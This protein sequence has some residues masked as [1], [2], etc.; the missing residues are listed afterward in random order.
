VVVL[1]AMYGYFGDGQREALVAAGLL[2]LIWLPALRCPTPVAA[3]AGVIAEGSLYTYLTHFQVYPLFSHPLP[4]VLAS[5]L[6]GSGLAWA[7]TAVRRRV[8][9][10][11]LLRPRLTTAP[12]RRHYSHPAA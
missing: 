6:L 10:R 4:G 5:L 7:V 9:A 3:A 11:E 1:I 2:L 8:G 12:R